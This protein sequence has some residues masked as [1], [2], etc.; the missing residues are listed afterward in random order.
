MATWVEILVML[1]LEVLL[2]MSPRLSLSFVEKDSFISP[3]PI[4]KLLLPWVVWGLYCPIK[5]PQRW[6]ASLS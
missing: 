5:Q 2:L 1:Y 4:F 3:F 6:W